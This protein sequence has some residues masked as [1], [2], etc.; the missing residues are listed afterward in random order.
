ML[1]S[2]RFVASTG[3][4]SFSASTR[5]SWRPFESARSW[6]RTQTDIRSAEDWSRLGTR[7][8]DDVP[9]EPWR[10]YDGKYIDLRDWLG[11]S[12]QLKPAKQRPDT[13]IYFSERQETHLLGATV[14]EEEI[15]KSGDDIELFAMP[16]FSPLTFLFRP[17]GSASSVWAALAVKVGRR[18]A[19]SA[20]GRQW[21]LLDRRFDPRNVPH[22]VPHSTLCYCTHRKNLFFFGTHD[23]HSSTVS[24]RAGG[25]GKH[26]GSYVTSE[27]LSDRLRTAYDLG[28]RMSICDWLVS[29]SRPPSGYRGP[30]G[31]NANLL[32][33]AAMWRVLWAPCGVDVRFSVNSDDAS[34]A[35]L[36]DEPIVVRTAALPSIGEKKT[37]WSCKLARSMGHQVCPFTT[38]DDVAFVVVVVMEAGSEPD[39][40]GCFFFP[41]TVLV[42]HGRI[43]T[44][45]TGGVEHLL[46]YPPW[47]SPQRNRGTQVWQLP[48]YIDLS[49]HSETAL[50]ASRK[51]FLAI[52]RGGQVDIDESSPEKLNCD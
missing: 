20:R 10:V 44:G 35:R 8:P 12:P 51:K 19:K 46:L 22:V 30:G 14:V 16:Y 28:P 41:K 21:F 42:D 1:K 52:L 48:Y 2:Y 37:G 31:A 9:A 27:D 18:D 15:K 34:N 7:R 50:E 39:P 49:D 5:K 33:M 24:V 17:R 45:G 3:V 38:D 13:H 25:G 26:D 36:D 32:S 4:R 23:V 29:S 40:R 11:L 6:A 43:A 47:V